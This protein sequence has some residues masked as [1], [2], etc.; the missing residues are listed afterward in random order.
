M[1]LGDAYRKKKDF[2]KLVEWLNHPAVMA[3]ITVA[4]MYHKEMAIEVMGRQAILG[5]LQQDPVIVAPTNVYLANLLV[6]DYWKAMELTLAFWYFINFVL[7]KDNTSSSVAQFYLYIVNAAQ[8]GLYDESNI[9]GARPWEMAYEVL[10]L[11]PPKDGPGKRGRWNPLAAAAKWNVA[12]SYCPNFLRDYVVVQ[13]DP[14][15]VMHTPLKRLDGL[16]D[17]VFAAVPDESSGAGPAH[18][19]FS[20]TDERICNPEYDC[21][22]FEQQECLLLN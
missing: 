9:L 22:E 4:T 5:S 10:L 15:N 2:K 14:S 13:V 6:A 12:S 16:K 1:L 20:A 18:D 19:P 3:W 11:R 17:P 7:S 8:C 21:G